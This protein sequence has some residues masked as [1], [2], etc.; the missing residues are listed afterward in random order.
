MSI[1]KP[2][3]PVKAIFVRGDADIEAALAKRKPKMLA[4][5]MMTT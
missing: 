5:N 2:V 3:M 4:I 1:L